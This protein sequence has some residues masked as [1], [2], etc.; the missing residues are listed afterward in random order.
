MFRS[1]SLGAE[2]TRRP[3][4]PGRHVLRPRVL[5]LSALLWGGVVAGVDAQVFHGSVQQ[6]DT[7]QPLAGA[8]VS[9]VDMSGTAVR[10]S[11]AT[12]QGGFL[13]TAPSAGVYVLRAEYLGFEASSSEAISIEVGERVE[14]RFGLS[15]SAVELTPVV[16]VAQRARVAARLQEYFER[17]DADARIGRGR[18]VTRADL[19]VLRPS[20]VRQ[21]VQMA[22]GQPQCVYT[23]FVDGMPI[24]TTRNFQL[25]L[26]PVELEGME[27]YRGSFEI[28]ARYFR[29]GQ[30]GVILF[31]TKQGANEGVRPTGSAR[32][33]IAM[34]LIAALYK[35][36]F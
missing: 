15:V 19:D 21:L 23:V 7:Q 30:C 32:T 13:L 34:G 10:R 22:P 2:Q 27:I 36:M 31:W 9:L 24:T 12:A 18:I 17:A 6:Q 16:A 3:C 1:A 33:A 8:T 35:V 20:H 29:Y 26:R 11:V 5:L 28:P 14:V 4:R 25:D